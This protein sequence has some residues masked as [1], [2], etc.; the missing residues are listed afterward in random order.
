MAVTGECVCG[1]CPNGLCVGCKRGGELCLPNDTEMRTPQMLSEIGRG[2][3]KTRGVP[4]MGSTNYGPRGQRQTF[5]NVTGPGFP[6]PQSPI[7]TTGLAVGGVFL[8][9]L[10][11]A[12]PLSIAYFIYKKAQK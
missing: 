7:S 1:S 9:I 5:R 4:S 12:V 2:I 3:S 8:S 11:F 10:M 6:P